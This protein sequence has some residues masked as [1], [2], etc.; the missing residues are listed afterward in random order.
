MIPSLRQ[1]FELMDEY[2]MLANIRD[3]S[4]LVA[5]VAGLVAENL[6]RRG[7]AVSV[8]LAVAGALLHDIAKTACLDCDGN[9]AAMGSE[10]CRRHDYGEI[11]GIVAEHVLLRDGLA[12]GCCREKEIV[13]YADKRV[14]HDRVVGLDERLDYIL[15]RYGRNDARLHGLIRENFLLCRQVEERIFALLPW[16]PAELA[17]R[18]AH[19][20]VSLGGETF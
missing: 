3:H 13:Y 5:R 9:H 4:L 12:P 17:G 8:E 19:H 18:A 15:A 20:P 2:R 1:C 7:V 16:R 10:I 6:A 14:L 11:A